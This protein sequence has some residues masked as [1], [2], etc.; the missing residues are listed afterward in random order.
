MKAVLKVQGFSGNLGKKLKKYMI[1]SMCIVVSYFKGGVL[2]HPASNIWYTSTYNMYRQ[3][4]EFEYTKA[5]GRIK[6]NLPQ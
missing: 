4:I 3:Y 2:S 6:I 5:S 1:M